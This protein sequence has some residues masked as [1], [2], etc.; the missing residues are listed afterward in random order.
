MLAGSVTVTATISGGISTPSTMTETT[1]ENTD[2]DVVNGVLVAYNGPGGDVVIPDNLGITSIGDGVF[3]NN[4]TITSVSIPEGVITIGNQVFSG[5][6]NLTA[7]NVD[8]NNSNYS[9]IDGVLFNKDGTRL[10]RCPQGKTGWYTI[11]NNVLT[12]G[13]G[14]FEYSRLTSVT[15]PESTTTIEY[16]AFWNCENLTDIYVQERINFSSVN[17][18][19]YNYDYTTLVAYPGGKPETAFSIPSTVTTIAQN[20]FV[21]CKNLTSIKIPDSVT[22]IEFEAFFGCTGLTS[23][24]IPESVAYIGLESFSECSS[25]NAIVVNWTTAGNIPIPG[26]NAFRGISS[27]AI[28]YVPTGAEALYEAAAGWKDFGTITDDAVLSDFEVVNGVLVAYY[29]AGGDVVIPDNLGITEIGDNVFE[30]NNTITSAN[31]PEGVTTVGY[32]AFAGSN[33]NSVTFPSTLVSIKDYAFAWCSNL[34]SVTL[35]TTLT[36]IGYGAFWNCGLTSVNISNTVESIGQDAF[37]AC[38]GLMAINVEATN[39][40]YSSVDGV[41]YNKDQTILYGYPSGKNA[42]T[43]TIPNSVNSIGNAA[44]FNCSNLTSITIPNSVNSIGYKVFI[45][46]NNLTSVVVNWTTPLSIANNYVFDGVSLS[47]CTLIV[48]VGKVNDYKADPVWGTFGT[49]IEQAPVSGVTF[50]HPTA[51]VSIGQTVQ[52]NATV[53]PAGAANKNVTWHSSDESKATVS[54]TGLVSG[55]SEG[56]VTITA[57]TEEGG[58]IASC[59]VTVF[60]ANPDFEVVNGVL[61]AYHG[62]GGDVVIPN[63]LGI[64]AIGDYVFA[65]WDKTIT[66]VNIPEGITAIGNR[67][68]QSCQFTSVT[69]PNSVETI[70]DGAFN[71]SLLTSVT[72]PGSVLTMG[73]EVFLAC[74]QLSAINVDAVNPNYSSVDGVLYN[75]SQSDLICYPAG[76]PELVFTI[77]NSVTTIEAYAFFNNTYLNAVIIPSTV[78]AIGDYAFAY[79]WGISDFYVNWNTPI[80]MSAS[81]NAFSSLYCYLHVPANT[82]NDYQTAPVWKDFVNIAEPTPPVNIWLQF[83]TPVYLLAG[84]T[85]QVSTWINPREASQLINWSSD[86]PLIASVSATGLITAKGLGTATITVA[87]QEYPNV[88]ATFTV[89]VVNTDFVVVNNVLV[90]YLGSNAYV[91]IPDNLGIKEIGDAAF[92]NNILINSVIIPEGVTKIGNN[93]FFGCSN[94]T[95]VTMPSTLESI[96]SNAFMQS[97]FTSITIPR[98]VNSIGINA[99]GYC[100][101]LTAINVDATNPNF[102]SMDG[103]LYNKDKT[104]L[105]LYPFGG[106]PVFA[107]P[108]TVT[109][110]AQSAFEGCNN[111]TSVTIPASVSTIE[112]AAFWNCSG[113]TSI[114][115]PASVAS[116]GE[117]VFTACSSLTD[118]TVYRSTPLA[119]PD[120]SPSNNYLFEYGYVDLSKVTL[121]VP[122]G[123]TSL[124]QVA[125]VWKDFGTIVGDVVLVTGVTLNQLTATLNVGA[126]L[127]LTATVAPSNATDKNVTWSSSNNS[128]A[129]VS[130]TGLVTALSTG[131]ATITA[132]TNG[133]NITATASITVSATNKPGDINGDG[134]VTPAD[135]GL[136]LQRVAGK[137]TFT[138]AQQIAA[139]VNNSGDVTPADAGLVLQRVAGKIAK[140]PVEP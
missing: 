96:G 73:K 79:C 59:A 29:G 13:S 14:A 55:V 9:S 31:I 133:G 68:F 104:T 67:S 74:S 10:I 32:R 44:F 62:V 48:P 43:F 6:S 78:T 95:S 132:T 80:D 136:I 34:N 117:G 69:I 54:A 42:I 35:P 3:A 93:T 41:L 46:C 64:T 8:N 110:I 114:T 76:K 47:A 127:Q 75:K 90:A 89:N 19:L 39:L 2:F 83:N 77:P 98:S 16:G 61:V 111:L 57:T 81:L 27:N 87:A 112:F 71:N 40:N 99:F 120:Y 58:F 37:G 85:K 115:L 82:L 15:I 101:N 17:G 50:D 51:S 118:F 125:P 65:I 139:D 28:L 94:L 116:M 22:R 107:I 113:L 70:G 30:N 109:D 36:T 86:N 1:N 97:G 63:N 121:H 105:Y 123:T 20:A 56:T 135:A 11:P 53:I 72:I 4:N 84:Q 88:S 21:Y 25:L 92:Q 129:T 103:V 52:L 23:V 102:S 119:L 18:V 100:Y 33:I 5:C 140:F 106:N 108:N 138:S 24:R 137:I 66:S 49:I 130:A 7:I 45:R 134:N 12:I 91:V 126:T 60:T 38:L 122:A 26:L 124:Y 131:S 128:I